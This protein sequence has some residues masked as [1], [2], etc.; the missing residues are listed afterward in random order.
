[1][2]KNTIFNFQIPIYFLGLIRNLLIRND[3]VTEQIIKALR[4]NFIA[5]STDG[6]GSPSGLAVL[7]GS[8][9]TSYQSN[10]DIES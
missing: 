8:Y 4:V 7:R 9:S 5:A 10:L 3:A 1:M 2:S 6:R